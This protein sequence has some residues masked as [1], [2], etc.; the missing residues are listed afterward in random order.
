M[1]NAA[2]GFKISTRMF[3]GAVAVALVTAV[4]WASV[5]AYKDSNVERLP[6]PAPAI[7]VVVPG[8]HPVTA[9]ITFTGAISARYDMPITLDAES[10]RIAAVYVEAGD[11]VRRGQVLA[12]LDTAVAQPQVVSLAASLDEARASAEIALADFQRA[13]GVAASGALSKEEIERRRSLAV[14][15]QARVKVAAAQYA[16]ARARLGRTDIRAPADGVVLMRSAEVGQTAVPGATPLFRL[17]RGGE[18]EM[19]GQVAEQDLPAL[20]LGQEAVVTVTGSTEPFVGKVRLLAAVIDP[21]TRLGEIRIALQPHPN[22][23]PGAFA[24]AAVIT[25]RAP[26]AI[27]PQSAILTAGTATYV[28]IVGADNKIV[29][30]DVRLGTTAKGGIVVES[31]LTGTERVVGTAAGFLR[32]GETVSIITGAAG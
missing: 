8:M 2:P 23:R 4:A 29:R 15:A 22:L 9:Q 12:R 10:A 3:L 7:T 28:L 11:R 13:Q 31:G 17:G 21:Q 5:R 6:P 32:E 26:R 20:A 14:T 25:G 18:V 27:V 30:R 24:R 19:R 1:A 16:E